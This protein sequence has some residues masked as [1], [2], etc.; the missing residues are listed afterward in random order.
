MP[1]I[2][3][4][5]VDNDFS[6]KDK[7][8]DHPRHYTGVHITLS[9]GREIKFGISTQQNCCENWN[10][11]HSTD[12]AS[13]YIGAE[14][15]GLTEKDTWPASIPEK[16]NGNDSGGFQAI[17]IQTNKGVLQFVVYN[18]HN[19]FYSHAVVTVVGDEITE[20]CL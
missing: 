11:L 2:I 13:D 6:V 19:G 12:A 17:D 8:Y 16:I 9:D 4:V 18:E 14:Y 15:I 5:N 3:A 1:T 20:T 10:Y 7:T